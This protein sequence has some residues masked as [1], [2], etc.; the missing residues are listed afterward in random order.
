MKRYRLGAFSCVM[1]SAVMLLAPLG[2][3][4]RGAS[5]GDILKATGVT[6]GLVVHVGC[7]DGKLTAA[8]AASDA[9]LVHGLDRVAGN[10]AT[11][12][13]H[14]RS[15]KLPGK[16]TVEL[17]R[18]EHLPYVS[19]T[20]N[21]VVVED[22]GK[23]STAEVM[24]V[25]CPN[26]VAYI[27]GRK[28]VKPRP[29]QIDDWTHYMHAADGNA[30]ADDTVA[31]PPR[32]IQWRAGPVFGRHHDKLA[33][34]STMV[35][36]GGR[37][38]C[39]I[40]EGPTSLLHFPPKWRLV[41]RDAFNGKLLWTKPIATWAD[42]MRAFRAGPAQLPRRLVAT[43]GRVYV[44]LGLHAPVTA[45]DAAT[46]KVI[47]TYAGTAGTDEILVHDGLLLVVIVHAG[48]GRADATAERRGKPAGAGGKAVWAVHAES[49]TVAWKKTG[50]ETADL[51]PMTL[52]A[53]GQRVCYQAGQAVV[54]VDL[55]TGREIWRHDRQTA[56]KA[57]KPTARR[58]R[59]P[60]PGST[61]GGHYAPTLV[62]NAST[63]VV[64]SAHGGKVTALSLDK[65]KALWTAPCPVDFR[66][67]ADLFV[68][69]GLV[70]PG[71]FSTKGRNARTGQV[72]N[73]ALDNIN[74][75]IT[76]GHH[77]RCHRNMAT[78]NYIITDKHGMEFID[79]AGKRHSRNV[80]VRGGCQFGML[81]CNG[82][83][84]MP[85][86]ACCCYQGAMLHG[87]YAFAPAGRTTR[88]TASGR[89]EK[90]PAYGKISN[91][92]S[93]ISDPNSQISDDD[94]PTFRGDALRSGAAGTAVPAG[95][96]TL[97]QAKV[98][99]KLRPPVIAAGKVLVPSENAGTVTCLDAADGRALWTFH[100]AG[101]I[102]SP[103]TIWRGRV[104]FGSADGHVYCVALADGKLARRFRAA[105]RD[106]R[107][108]VD[109]QLESVW[110]VPGSVL[111][112]DGVA[113]FA[114][115]RSTYLDGGITLYG[116]DAATGEKRHETRH[117][118]DHD[119]DGA[120]TFA[121]AGTVGDVLT[122][123]GKWIYLK[124]IKFDR[125][126]VRQKSRGRHLYA[127]SGLT[128]DQW[129]YRSFWKLG[130]GGLDKPIRLPWSYRKYNMTVPFGQLLV[131]DEKSTWGLQTKFPSGI[132][133][134]KPGFWAVKLFRTPNT[135]F[136]PGKA[137]G[138][139]VNDKPGWPP[140]IKYAWE[141]D[142]PFQ[143]RAMVMDRRSVFV[144]GWPDVV[145]AKDPYAAVEG[146]AGGLLW[147]FSRDGKKR[148]EHAL[149]SS[150]VFDGMAA[151]GGRLYVAMK[152]GSVA[153]L[154][155]R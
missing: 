35:S 67:P 150:P 76:P 147:V 91:L 115:G 83:V 5:A 139:D 36:S 154:G 58:K 31:G 25:L 40:D 15:Q 93:Q 55:K 114:A 17:W 146:R 53:A 144:A 14:L 106:L 113:Y 51:Q 28:T 102:D 65:G 49:G 34:L 44:T 62:M 23:V 69:N 38:F 94:W 104:L 59:R 153:C 63:G 112:L 142:L 39:I 89:L 20:V 72:E 18:G 98:G 11:A 109:D 3:A 43:G 37:L 143:A 85:P 4:A 116:L 138:S 99:G 61:A 9:L 8:L 12:R 33:S 26:G 46:G 84:Y 122:A 117:A 29:D 90:G 118:V 48:Q 111:V 77:P 124:D 129:F 73:V 56:A 152:N 100:A 137:S 54:C 119:K 41:A 149:A 79:L 121:M 145:R 105:P 108:V 74:T 133:G 70:Y 16:A 50:P 134:Y 21:L 71:L 57:P 64:L 81:P 82:L 7:G 45:L 47:K 126:L 97:W 127:D 24:R 96:K 130:Y 66:A 78:T 22:S 75:L 2:G 103:P 151:A 155:A 148:A 42:H 110:P 128:D 123:D 52:A 6:G 68:I 140:P 131:F 80:W 88:E 60:K 141:T 95:L 1:L 107:V 120:S 101:R 13:E 135:P 27:N 32:R 125:K 19:N 132:K 87:L 136:D 92:K 30:V 10:V 86:N